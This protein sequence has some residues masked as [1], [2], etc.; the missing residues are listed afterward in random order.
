MKAAAV[1]SGV[2]PKTVARWVVR[3]RAEG[4]A[5]LQDRSSSLHKLC[6]PAPE[7]AIR[8]IETLWCQRWTGQWIVAELYASPPTANRILHRLRLS[9][10][11]DIEPVPVV[12]RSR[13]Q[14]H[15][16]LSFSLF[17]RLLPTA[18]ESHMRLI[19]YSFS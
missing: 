13:S 8:W 18:R 1:A 5:D 4:I 7:S 14:I 10:I 11:K 2:C 3:F 17:R 15:F 19:A 9:R 6:N 12:A 16:L